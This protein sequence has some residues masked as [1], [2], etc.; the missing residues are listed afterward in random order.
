MDGIPALLDPKFV[1]AKKADSFLKPGDRVLALTLEGISK[2]YPIK[3]LNW[4]ELVNDNFKRRPVF[5]SYCPLCGTGMAF[6]SLIKG[7]I[8]TFGISGLLYNSD[9][10][11]YDHQTGSLWSQID[12][13]AVTGKMGGTEL[14]PL[15]VL[16]TTWERW[17]SMHSDTLVLSRDTGY[18]RDYDRNPYAGYE[19]DNRLMFPV[20]EKDDRYGAKEWTLGVKIKGAAKAYP[21]SELKKSPE[22]IDDEIGGVKIKVHFDKKSRTAFVTDKDGKLISSVVGF[23]FAWYA[24]NPD[25][26]VYTAQ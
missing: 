8:Y 6:D 13:K 1:S 9:V 23:W 20:S 5:V 10:L 18:L 16:H 4:H 12:M 19:D 11:F 17:K 7:R 3:I 2:A 25:T 24:F 14:S 15:P 26:Q 22:V 21:F